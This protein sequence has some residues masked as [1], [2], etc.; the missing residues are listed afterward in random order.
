MSKTRCGTLW[1]TLKAARV[2]YP[3]MVLI[4]TYEMA[5]KLYKAPLT[6]ALAKSYKNDTLLVGGVVQ[7]SFYILQLITAPI[8]GRIADAGF[9]RVTLLAAVVAPLI[10]AVS[11][12]CLSGDE[13]LRTVLVVF[14]VATV[15]SGLCGSPLA[16]AF[17][18]A[19][20]LLR[21]HESADVA[22]R[23]MLMVMGCVPLGVLSGVAISS[24]LKD[25]N[26]NPDSFHD[27][28]FPLSLTASFLLL[29]LAVFL[30]VS[31]PLRYGQ[32]D[33]SLTASEHLLLTDDGEG[34]SGRERGSSILEILT[35]ESKTS[36]FGF[37]LGP[38]SRSTMDSTEAH[39]SSN[40]K[41]R[42]CS[43]TKVLYV[44]RW[45]KDKRFLYLALSFAFVEFGH[46]GFFAEHGASFRLSFP[47][48]TMLHSI[49]MLG[50][51]LNAFNILFLAPL[52]TNLG[53][54]AFAKA[55]MAIVSMVSCYS[56]WAT[57]NYTLTFVGEFTG[58]MALMFK[59]SVT[60]LLTERLQGE[61]EVGEAIGA[62]HGFGSLGS[63]VGVFAASFAIH[64]FGTIGFLVCACGP[65]T[66]GML[67]LCDR[68]VISRPSSSQ[69]VQE[70]SA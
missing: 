37:D 53:A 1:K 64:A 56:L 68:K 17:A 29:F 16:V 65:V 3:A 8:W 51:A 4:L 9:H 69:S 25:S 10:P 22:A 48:S 14:N 61:T 36:S 39:T 13:T 33:G 43:C 40:G 23:A 67:L 19:K 47:K 21:V 34:H 31:G 70:S 45:L 52:L 5:T 30:Y 59:P 26:P 15:C 38:Q 28:I 12:L 55:L 50:A 46:E 6:N 24:L 54:N 60:F 66:A 2:V 20:H 63:I 62:L 49:L 18:L 11:I 41:K 57:G 7:S 58:L 42:C 44:L 35:R 32:K 27:V